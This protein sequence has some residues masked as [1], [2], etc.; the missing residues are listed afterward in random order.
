[1]LINK[2]KIFNDPVYGF[3]NIPY[4]I[5]FD[6]IEHPTFQRLRRI[7]QLG[8]TYMVFPGTNHTRFQHALGCV[9]LMN[10]A[11]NILKLKGHSITEKESIGVTL[12]ILLHDIG[13]GPFSH[14]LERCLINNFS[15]EDLSLLIMN[16]LNKEFNNQLSLAIKIFKGDY[17]K[18]FLHQ[19]VS[20]QLD[21]DRLDYLKR[22]SFF[23]GVTEGTIGSDRIIKMLNVIN[24]ELVIESKG[25]YSIE[26]FLISRRLMYWQV[27]LHKTV[28]AAENLLI[29]LLK[30]AKELAMSGEK[31]FATDALH[32]FLVNNISREH[33]LENSKKFDKSTV[34]HNFTL[35]DDND[36]IISAKYWMS[37]PDKVLSKLAF[38]LINR[39]LFKIEI[40]NQPFKKEIIQN[41]K[42]MVMT[43]Y[44]ISLNEADYFVYTDFVSNSLYKYNEDDNIKILQKNG[45]ILE[46]TEASDLL[47]SSTLSANVKKFFLCYP[48]ECYE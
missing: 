4:D 20:S 47:Y 48:K 23:S 43:K 33:F 2:R 39:S 12:A 28:L 8:L 24:D 37:H 29:L 7:K 30:R 21:M 22:D 9:H 5:V 10:Q 14:T 31:L 3:I 6:L 35:L 25:I 44:N 1:M 41:L 11:L 13:H 42:H 26:K 34:I 16:E 27:Y 38:N 32:F 36:I 15:H 18:N 19:L 40:K 46:L 17:S 45:E